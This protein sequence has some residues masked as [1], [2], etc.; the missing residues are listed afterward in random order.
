MCCS[1]VV[2][3]TDRPPKWIK[4]QLTRLVEEAPS[5]KD[6]LREMKYDGYSC[7]HRRPA[8]RF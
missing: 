4:P 2:A 8:V 5:G 1:G 6:W 7:P 3:G